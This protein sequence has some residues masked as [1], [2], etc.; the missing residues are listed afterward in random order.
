[1]IAVWVCCDVGMARPLR[2]NIADGWYHV[3]HRGIERRNIF[4]DARDYRHFL[5]LFEELCV[6]YRFRIH[7][8]CL[9]DN[10][11]HA[12]VQTPDANLSQGMQW[13]GLAFSSWFNARH[14]RSG[15]L[16]QGRFR[17]VPVED[18]AWVY[19]LSKYIHL[20]P[21]RTVEFG[22]DK[23]GNRAEGRGLTRPP[24]PEQV[25]Q[26]LKRLREYP[27]SSYRS[28]GGYAKAAKWL[29][30][31]EIMKRA[32]SQ[33]EESRRRYR[34]D[35]QQLLKRGVEEGRL[36]KF[37]EVVAIGS[38]EFV[39]R[40]RKL[41]G[42]GKRETERRC[43]LRPAVG[44][45]EVVATVEKVRGAERQEWINRH[46]D[47]GKWVVLSVARRYCGVT[48]RQLGDLMGGMDY[49]AVC[50][51]LRRFEKRLQKDRSARKLHDDT[52]QML[53]V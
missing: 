10:H 41:A 12:V 36:D 51:G 33:G 35:V 14:G 46:G 45:E 32:S 19:E 24:T 43:R 23:R 5:S 21:V 22:L 50:M 7:A 9:L 47:Y 48:L 16:F 37:K 34:M 20:N 30:T 11:Y 18:G 4:T 28:Y 15:P 27:W 42:E 13:F 44:F 1:L 31:T 52:I 49:A 6:R 3:M 29:T 39:E 25:A 38:A 8:Y 2:V 26:R 40:V 17:S 53:N